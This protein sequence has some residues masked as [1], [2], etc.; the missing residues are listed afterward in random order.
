[1]TDLDERVSSAQ[2]SY[3][4]RT[5]KLARSETN[6]READEK[7]SQL[8]D[9]TFKYPDAARAKF[10]RLIKSRGLKRAVDKMK[11]KPTDAV[12]GWK[13]LKGEFK[14]TSGPTRERELAIENLQQIDRTYRA[15][16]EAQIEHMLAKRL[17]DSAKQALARLQ[18]ELPMIE[19]QPIN[20]IIRQ[21]RKL[22]QT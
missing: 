17:Q 21:K 4:L 6:L 20:Q 1:M 22:R 13:A 5:A 11:S 8:F 16:E 3:R 7:L 12:P 2:R 14:I 10:A 18:R 19:P 15:V 9:L